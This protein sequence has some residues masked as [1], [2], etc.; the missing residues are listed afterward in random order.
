MTELGSEGGSFC[1]KTA[2]IRK[3]V[4]YPFSRKKRY[5]NLKSSYNLPH[6]TAVVYDWHLY[7]GLGPIPKLKP[8]LAT[9]TDTET[10]FSRENLVTDSMRY[11]FHHKRAPETKFSSKH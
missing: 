9:V 5:L 3:K 7:F 11:F 6:L 10:T 4:Y 2:G 8:K 1:P